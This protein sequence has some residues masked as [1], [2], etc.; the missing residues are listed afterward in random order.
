MLR[1]F[2]SY[3]F[4]ALLFF[5]IGYSSYAQKNELSNKAQKNAII[6]R[7][8]ET[9]A[10]NLEDEDIDFTTLFDLLSAYYE[11]PI[12]L[13][14]KNIK[15]DL[16]QTRLLTEFQVN[17]VIKHVEKNG[18]L[19]SIYELQS[20]EGFDV[21]TIRKIMPFVTVNTELYSP[22]TNFKDL[23]E[24]ASNTI[25]LRYSRVLEEQKG[26]RDV[27]DQ[28]WLDS[29]NTKYLG[30][31]DKL[32]MRYRFKYLNNVSIGVTMEKDAGESF[33]GN[34]RATELFGI[35]Q[36]KGFDYYSAHFYL[37]NIGKVKG[38]A[39]GD[40][41]MQIGQGLTFW[42]GLAFGK[43]VDV[44]SFKRNAQ[45]IRP[46]ASVDE[47]NFLRGAALTFAPIKNIE[48]TAFGS[49]KNIDANLLENSDTTLQGLDAIS[50]FTSFQA[51]GNHNTIGTLNDKDLLQ[52]T[53]IGGNI[54]F[55]N[56]SL[57]VGVTGV[58]SNYNG[59]LERNLVPYSQFQ[60]NSNQNNVMGADYSYIYKNFNIYGELSRSENGGTAML[61]GVLASLDPKLSA[62]I[63]YRNYG[64]DYQS[65]R[66]M[67]FAE[68]STNVNEK[69]VIIGLEAKPNLKWTI[70]AYMDQFEFPWMRYLT[71]K[72][73]TFGYDGLLQAKYKHSKKIELY[74]RIRNR[75]KP[76]NTEEDV[77]DI[78]PVVSEKMWNYRFNVNYKISETIQLKNRVE[79]R[80][81]KRGNSPQENGYLIYQDIAYKPL[82][83]PFSFTFRYALFD[84]DSYDARIYAYESNVLY[85]YSI[86]AYY[87]RGTRVQLTTRYRIR[88]GID[89]WLR[90]A[91]WYYNDV[92]TIGTAL[93]EIN[94]NTK[95][96]VTAQVRFKF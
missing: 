39:I 41:H 81:Y 43:T 28:E 70:N 79:F 12:N 11:T 57:K 25:F 90:W 32:Y 22:H 13:N 2:L 54:K 4:V 77:N 66:S 9:I 62:S 91:Q 5:L 72:P 34:E 31:Q 46:Y 56:N 1:Y 92:E 42:S 87:N 71:D 48:I 26:Y 38:L 78:T 14:G 36:N 51:T 83:S 20:V 24:N 15:D 86:P 63:L 49:R 52:E 3:H 82:S 61:H 59:N 33:L 76:K 27:T 68:S 67:A 30:S 23:M 44:M 65:I 53:Y 55:V 74:G 18:I 89:V 94:G 29:E 88:K 19:M 16:M 21:Q 40:Y 64:R 17:A 96:Q 45:G 93:E 8:V 37:K 84:M 69:G 85:A 50:T 58:H 47:N 75:V 7:S 6:E 35:Q 60:F 95:T 10:E 80:T 73:N